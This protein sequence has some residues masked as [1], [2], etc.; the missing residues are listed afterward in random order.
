MKEKQASGKNASP[1][2]SKYSPKRLVLMA[3]G[4]FTG[5]AVI[6]VLVLV[7]ALRARNAGMVGRIGLTVVLVVG[8]A[9]A[10]GCNWV[11][12][13]CCRRS[14]SSSPRSPRC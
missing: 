7:F 3:L 10:P 5:L 8:S 11:R 6:G 9:R 2:S 12:P 4:A 1:A 13:T 14:A